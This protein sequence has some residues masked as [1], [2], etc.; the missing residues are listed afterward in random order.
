MRHPSGNLLALLGGYHLMDIAPRLAHLAIGN[1]KHKQRVDSQGRRQRPSQALHT[2]SA[3][4]A[5]RKRSVFRSYDCL[6]KVF[7]HV[8]QCLV[9]NAVRLASHA[10]SAAKHLPT[11]LW[12]FKARPLAMM[13]FQIE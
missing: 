7:L 12:A 2:V 6:R 8:D 1:R 9:L 11:R 10:V 13:L 3:C 4:D 5:A